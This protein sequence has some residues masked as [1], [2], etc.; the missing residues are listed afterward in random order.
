MSD[1]VS[2]FTR[3]LLLLVIA[4]VG[5]RACALVAN[6]TILPQAP[7]EAEPFTSQ[8]ATFFDDSGAATSATL[9]MSWG[10]TSGGGNTLS[11]SSGNHGFLVTLT[12]TANVYVV[13]VSGVAAFA[14]AGPGLISLM[15]TDTS[16]SSPT[17]ASGTSGVLPSAPTFT[18]LPVQVIGTGVASGT[19]TVNP[20][21]T[22]A[23]FQDY[24]PSDPSTFTA[25]INWGDGTAPDPDTPVSTVN[26]A[27]S[28]AVFTVTN[29]L[30]H[31]YPNLG[32]FTISVTINDSSG[33]AV[34]AIVA[35]T[36]S[37][38]T[39]I[40]LTSSSPLVGGIPTSTFGDLVT[41]SATITAADGSALTGE[42][43]FFSDGSPMASPGGA[44]GI[45]TV[46]TETTVVNNVTYYTNVTAYGFNQLAFGTHTITASYGGDATHLAC[47]TSAPQ[48]TQT[49]NAAAVTILTVSSSQNPVLAGFSVTFTA[50]VESGNGSTPDGVVTFFDT[51]TELAAVAVS[52]AG[53]TVSASYTTSLLATGLHDIRA[54]YTL[55][56]NVIPLASSATY[57]NLE[58]LV[59]DGTPPSSSSSSGCGH[60]LGVSILSLALLMALRST[61]IRRRA[62]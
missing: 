18:V 5:S 2:A 24:I 39:T 32:T 36:A 17:V 12:S 30:I 53:S 55:D 1:R 41:F 29:N 34:T 43:N 6:V 52:G 23:S 40:V 11:G 26:A 46:T 4:M 48:L 62:V 38:S 47:I 28:P 50:S 7:I 61:G 60:G 22:I 8:I 27:L 16:G 20:G 13:S 35:Y 33:G 10:P 19:V 44:S 25:T 51:D 54:T 15:V 59:T 3:F 37:T 42:V 21:T 9:T 58:E 45:A 57:N 14:N 49:V 56:T 31:V